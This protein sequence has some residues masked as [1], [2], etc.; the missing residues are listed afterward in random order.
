MY[1][2]Y[3]L[4][5]ESRDLLLAKFPPKYLKVICHH[6]TQKF[7]VPKDTPPPPQPTSVRVIGYIDDGEGMEVLLAEVDGKTQSPEGK[8]Y[9]IT[10]SLDSMLGYKPVDANSLIKNAENIEK[11]SPIKIDTVSTIL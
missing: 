1:T 6:I 7:G 4:T 9:H 3:L 10:H 11:V 8:V 2:C 5:G